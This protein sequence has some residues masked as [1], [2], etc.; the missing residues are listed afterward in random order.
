MQNRIVDSLGLRS[1]LCAIIEQAVHDAR[2]CKGSKKISATSF[3]NSETYD[4]ICTALKLPADSIRNAAIYDTRHNQ[5]KKRKGRQATEGIQLPEVQ[6]ELRLD[7]QEEEG[8][9]R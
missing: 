7:L 6:G 4:T 5:S 2:F 1:V 8:L 9:E 3:L